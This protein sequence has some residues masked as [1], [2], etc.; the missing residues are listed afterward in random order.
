M[1]SKD[2]ILKTFGMN[3]SVN[4]FVAPKT[5]RGEPYEFVVLELSTRFRNKAKV[6]LEMSALGPAGDEVAVLWSRDD[7]VDMWRSYRQADVNLEKREQKIIDYMVPGFIFTAPVGNGSF[8]IPLIGKRPIPKPATIKAR[9]L[10][11]LTESN[12]ETILE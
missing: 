7:F 3:Q 4:P 8:I 2:E 9:V 1:L 12:F 5:I 11:G 6:E 10:Y